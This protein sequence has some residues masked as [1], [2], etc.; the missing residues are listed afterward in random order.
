MARAIHIMEIS[1]DQNIELLEMIDKAL[2][3]KEIEK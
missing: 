1:V 2:M 3:L